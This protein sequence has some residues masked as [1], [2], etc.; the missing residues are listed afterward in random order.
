MRSRTESLV[1]TRDLLVVE[2]RN[3]GELRGAHA[4]QY[5]VVIGI[6]ELRGADGYKHVA[7]V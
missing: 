3:R 1:V 2:L 5:D 4:T 6:I 7:V